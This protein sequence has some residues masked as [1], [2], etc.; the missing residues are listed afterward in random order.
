MADSLSKA[1]RSWNMGR[2]KGV[3]TKPEIIVRSELHKAGFRFRLHQQ[4]LPGKP[5]IVLKK[6]RTVIFVNGC[7]WHRHRNCKYS[8]I[9]KT[10][11]AFWSRKFYDNV[12]RDQ[13][14]YQKL[15]ETGWNVLIIWECELSDLKKIGLFISSHFPEH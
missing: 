15:T 7:F 3:N 11:K 2:I 6:F 13:L 14:N 10:R 12:R 9:P 8:Y 5:D 1:K 4:G